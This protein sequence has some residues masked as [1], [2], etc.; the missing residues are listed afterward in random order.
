MKRFVLIM[1][2]VGVS[3][4]VRSANAVLPTAQD[5]YTQDTSKLPAAA[6]GFVAKHFPTETIAYILVDKE[7]VAT[8]YEVVLSNGQ[9]I[10]FDKS[11]Q[12]KEMEGK[13]SALPLSAMPE[14]VQTYVKANFPEVSVE[15]IERERWGYELELLNGLEVKL[16]K[17]G[18]AIEIEH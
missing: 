14:E 16:D 9:E 11:G 6:V 10:T 3:F 5:R 12:W 7:F 4:G 15:Q 13:K 2:A 17:K 8:D 1:M 18:R